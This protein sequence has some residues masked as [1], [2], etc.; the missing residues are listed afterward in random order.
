MKRLSELA[1]MD[2]V[3]FNCLTKFYSNEAEVNETN[4]SLQTRGKR[5]I[6]TTKK[7][8]PAPKK[9]KNVPSAGNDSVSFLG[10][11]WDKIHWLS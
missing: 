8:E 10:C 11:A 1:K 3:S 7:E 2:D 4:P 5:T 6:K 9:T